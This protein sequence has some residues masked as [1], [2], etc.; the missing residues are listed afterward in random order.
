MQNLFQFEL[1]TPSFVKI[2]GKEAFGSGVAPE[3]MYVYGVVF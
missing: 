3:I 1:G 2:N